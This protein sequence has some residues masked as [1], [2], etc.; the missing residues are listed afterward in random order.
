MA[1]NLSA[2]QGR[3][4]ATAPAIA[5]PPTPDLVA[6]VRA[7]RLQGSTQRQVGLPRWASIGAAAAAVALAVGVL[8]SA[9]SDARAALDSILEVGGLSITT[10]GEQSATPGALEQQLGRRAS[11]ENLNDVPFEILELPSRGD[12]QVYINELRQGTIVTLIY[13]GDDGAPVLV[14]QFIGE[15][16]AVKDTPG[17]RPDEV[18]VNGRQGYWLSGPHTIAYPF[19]SGDPPVREVGSVLFWEEDGVVIRIESDLTLSEVLALAA[20]LG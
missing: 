6:R 18:L 13:A 10:D 17:A 15:V 14:T 3:L 8:L 12:A 7:V 1:D 2:I 20:T 11:T 9:S 19:E 16:R 4:S 5:F